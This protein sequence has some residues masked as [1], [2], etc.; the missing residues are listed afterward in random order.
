M[1]VTFGNRQLSTHLFCEQC[2][3]HGTKVVRPEGV[4]G[5]CQGSSAEGIQNISD[6]IIEAC[7]SPDGRRW[8]TVKIFNSCKTELLNKRG[9]QE[10]NCLL[11]AE[12]IR[13]KLLFFSLSFFF[14]CIFTV[15][16]ELRMDFKMLKTA[17]TTEVRCFQEYRMR[18]KLFT[19]ELFE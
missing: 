6:K 18:R 19:T 8:R 4:A 5:S 12:R 2:R 3:H 7:D 17:L 16:T 9:R 13:P 15:A 10:N 11:S 14:N 1:T